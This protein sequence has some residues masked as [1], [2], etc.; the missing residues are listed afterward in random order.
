MHIK[1]DPRFKE[2]A[3]CLCATWDAQ[4]AGEHAGEEA[5]RYRSLAHE[6]A[7]EYG[8]EFKE[9]A[10]LISAEAQKQYMEGV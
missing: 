2:A 1:Q 3:E 9:T 7:D 8:K 5:K 6:L 4:D 10:H